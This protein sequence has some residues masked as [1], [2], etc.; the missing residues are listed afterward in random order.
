MS[1]AAY[2]DSGRRLNYMLKSDQIALAK[3]LGKGSDTIWML[4]SFRIVEIIVGVHELYLDH[5]GSPGWP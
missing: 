4:S 1:A 2:F 5:S 3:F